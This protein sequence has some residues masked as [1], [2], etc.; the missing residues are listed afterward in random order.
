M[1]MGG[2]TAKVDMYERLP[3]PFG[4]VRFG[5]APDHPEVK[6]VINDFAEVASH[7]NFR[8]FGNVDVGRD[9]SMDALER[10]YDAVVVC[11]GAEGEKV[12]GI[13]GEEL[14]G[15]VGAPHFV[16][17]YNGHPDYRALD[18]PSPG[19]TAVI[20]GQGNVALD[21]ARILTKSSN[22]LKPTD[23]EAAAIERIGQWQREGLREVQVIGRRGFAQA[24]YTNKELREQLTCSED[25]LAVVDPKDLELSRNPASEEELKKNRAKKRSIEIL[26]K[27]AANFAEKDTT[28][29]RVVWFRF[30]RSPT[31]LLS[32]DAGNLTAVRLAQNALEGDAGR[33]RAVLVPGTE[34]D[35]PCGLVVRSVGFDITPMEGVPLRAGRVPHSGGRVELD[36]DRVGRLYVSGWAKRGPTGVVASNIPDAQET[37]TSII[38]D[39]T[40]EPSRAQGA[41]LAEEAIAASGTQ[42]VSFQDWQRLQAEEIRRG[43]ADGRAAVKFNQVEPALQWLRA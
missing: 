38:K 32:S 26:E 28:S 3:V 37:A 34:E 18:V 1:K 20:L 6:N 31:A 43:Q 29:K 14:P 36:Q 16:K 39:V 10:A 12:L 5:V 33:Q 25:V 4:L 2:D 8:F 30:L 24:A 40:S 23:I 11:T 22:E 27:M 15:V 9:V 41:A 13:P 19:N 7:S 35:V 42:V 21:V 17:W